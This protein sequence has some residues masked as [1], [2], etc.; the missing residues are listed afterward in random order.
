MVAALTMARARRIIKVN[1]GQTLQSGFNVPVLFQV[2]T[3]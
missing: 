2:A 3:T 1:I